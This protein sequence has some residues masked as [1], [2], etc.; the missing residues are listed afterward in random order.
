M[1]KSFQVLVLLASSNILSAQMIY[2][3]QTFNTPRG[4]ITVNQP[5][6]MMP[7]Y[8]G[9]F[10]GQANPRFDFT[11][12][13]KSDSVINLKSRI[14]VEDKKMFVLQKEKKV[15]RKIFPNET[16]EIYGFSLSWGR[17][18]GVPAD[19][20][21]LFKTYKGAINSFSSLPMKD[22]GAVIAIQNGEDGEIV[23]LTKNNLK[24][25][26]GTEDEKIMKWLA[27]NKLTKAIDYYNKLKI[28]TPL[29]VK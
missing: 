8:N 2:A 25:M 29:L 22:Q 18:K 23:A 7:R 16:K 13:L 24:A 21:W 28:S 1:I 11:V 15:K 14:E 6:G 17:M 9:G 3:P 26:T 19:S 12:V 10:S 4:N 27:K 20:C 5:V